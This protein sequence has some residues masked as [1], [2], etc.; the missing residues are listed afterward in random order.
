MIAFYYAMTGFACAIYYRRELFK[1]AKNLLFIGVA[2]V[3]GSLML[4]YLFFKSLVDW[5]DPANSYTGASWFGFAPP[6]IIGVGF[7]LLG[8]ILLIA[9]RAHQDEPF[10]KRRREIADPDLLTGK[11]E[12]AAA[13][14]G[15]EG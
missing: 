3:I 9:W 10:F 8:V 2:P 7:L 5:T 6:A 11:T 12:P 13:L 4:T 14:S 15:S 1:S